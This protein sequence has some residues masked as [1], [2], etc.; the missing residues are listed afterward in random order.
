MYATHCPIQRAAVRMQSPH[1]KFSHTRVHAPSTTNGVYAHSNA[2][3][4]A[5]ART[6]QAERRLQRNRYDTIME[7]VGL[8]R[9]TA[10]FRLALPHITDA[11]KG[12]D[13][14]AVHMARFLLENDGLFIGSSSAM[15]CVGAVKIARELGPGHTVVTLLCDSGTR[16]VSKLY[17][18][19]YLAKRGLTSVY[20]GD[21]L[22]FVS[23]K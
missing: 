15:N 13:Q 8:D 4:R 18:P 11:F 9:L 1:V 3:P 10:N 5:H 12:T 16:A 23:D 2:H 22:S 7:G 19:Q 17:N 20:D 14:E 21:G 6:E